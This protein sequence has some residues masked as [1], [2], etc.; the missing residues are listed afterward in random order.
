[1]LNQIKLFF[2][3]HIALP[4]TEKSREENLRIACAALLIE[5]MH[6]D[7]RLKKEEQESIRARLEALFSLSPAQTN[8][9][10]ELAEDQRKAATDYFQFTHLINREFS[11]EQKIKLIE[12]LW[13]VAYADGDLSMYEEYLVRKISDLIGVSHTDFIILKNRVKAELTKDGM[14]KS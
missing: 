8:A 3:Q 1:M 14:A 2:E 5:M 12:S 13:R 4:P 10:T 11:T 6:M 7:D 9:L